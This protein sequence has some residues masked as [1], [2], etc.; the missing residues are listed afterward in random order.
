MNNVSVWLLERLLNDNGQHHATI[1]NYI[2][3][4]AIFRVGDAGDYLAVLLS[5]SVE[6]RK[7]AHLISAIEPGSMFGEMGIIDRHPRIA[8]AIAKNNS[9]IAEIRE[10]QFTS[11]LRETPEFGLAIMRILSDRLRKKIET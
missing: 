5:G 9:R 3:G 8:D 10:G 4:E 6:I 11:M 2:P 1:R 7:G